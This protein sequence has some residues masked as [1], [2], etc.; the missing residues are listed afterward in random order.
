MKKKVYDYLRTI[1]KGK[2]VTYG[3]I[4]EFLAIKNCPELLVIYFIII[5]MN[6]NIPVIKW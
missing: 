5:L 3:Q 2:V 6:T 4:A 1:P